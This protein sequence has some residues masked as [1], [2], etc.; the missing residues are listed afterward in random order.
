MVGTRSLPR[1]SRMTARPRPLAEAA[2]VDPRA[3]ARVAIVATDVDGTLTDRGE[4]RSP[5]VEVIARLIRAGVEV[6]PVSGRPA[7]EVLGLCR[8][9]PGV[10][11]GIAENGLLE[12]VPDRA[13]R[14]ISGRPTDVERL[15]AV[16]DWLNADHQ[17]GLQRTGDAFC[18]LGDVAYER[19]GRGEPELERLRE[20]ARERGVHLV[21]SNVHVHLAEQL[22]DKGEGLLQVLAQEGTD[23][24]TVA[25]IGDAPNDVGLFRP[26]RFGLTVGTRDVVDQLQQFDDLPQFVAQAREAAAFSELAEG[27]LA[28]G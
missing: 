15:L 5:I 22:P 1:S 12:V 25:T 18:R 4:L 10:T 2:R 24:T 21:W 9:L 6:I 27:L 11:R 23:P 3:W 16:G 28:R 13:P 19:E 7:G 17:A 8:Y 20:R 14:W 26:G